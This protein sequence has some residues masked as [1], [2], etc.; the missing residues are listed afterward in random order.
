MP[1]DP[2]ALGLLLGYGNLVMVG[3]PRRLQDAL[4]GVLRWVACLTGADRRLVQL[5]RGS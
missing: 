3:V 4:L 5:V 1:R 2:R